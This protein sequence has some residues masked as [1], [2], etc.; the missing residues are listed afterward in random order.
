MQ[1]EIEKAIV[2][3]DNIISD[4]SV[5]KNVRTASEQAQVILRNVEMDF[6][7]KRDS[8]SQILDEMTNDPNV[9]TFTRTQ[10]WAI[11]SALESSDA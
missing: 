7:V 6:E 2:L 11:V 3:F 8:V 9:E 10:I 5:P 4:K 1:N